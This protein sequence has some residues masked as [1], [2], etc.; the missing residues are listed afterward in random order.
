[1]LLGF[2]FTDI[3]EAVGKSIHREGALDDFE[4][5]LLKDAFESVGN[6]TPARKDNI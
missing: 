4:M 5:V 1:M 6:L 3:S 2:V